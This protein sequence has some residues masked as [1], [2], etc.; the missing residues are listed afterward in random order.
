MARR[1]DQ[2]FVGRAIL[3]CRTA[4]A[5]VQI[6]ALEISIGCPRKLVQPRLDGVR[7][8]KVMQNL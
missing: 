4:S 8:E 7:F 5:S 2:E 1:E 6:R 3:Q